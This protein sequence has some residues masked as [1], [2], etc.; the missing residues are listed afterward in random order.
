M[1][2]VRC[3]AG[4]TVMTVVVC[5]DCDDCSEVQGWNDCDD[6]GYYWELQG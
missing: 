1:T 4:M 6:C 5:D 3:K 2:V